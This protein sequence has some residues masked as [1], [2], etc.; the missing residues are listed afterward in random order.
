MK[1]QITSFLLAALVTF[2]AVAETRAQGTAFTYQGRLLQGTSPYSGAAEMRFI[3]FAVPS[4]GLPIST[5]APA[6]AIV[7]VSNGMFVA[8]LDFGPT[9]FS[10]GDRWI[11]IQLRTDLGDFIPLSPRQRVTPAPFALTARNV[12]GLDGHTLRTPDQNASPAVTVGPNGAVGIGTAAPVETLDIRSDDGSYVRVDR[13][14]G[15]IKVNGGSD[16]HW[17]I[18]NDGPSTGGTHLIG[19]GQTR[20]FVANMGNVGIGTLRPAERLDVEGNI[21][22]RDSVRLGSSGQWHATASDEILRMV[23]GSFNADGTIVAGSGFSVER[24]P[25]GQ[26]LITFHTPFSGTPTVTATTGYGQSYFAIQVQI[27]DLSSGGCDL[28]ST[29]SD[30]GPYTNRPVHFIAIGPR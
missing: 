3:M 23:R 1:P 29:P 9:A 26:Y 10:D 5:S 14:N 16:G 2:T 8:S 21:R 18:F 19:E 22:V 7:T 15:D 13:E 11:E 27:A 4:G 28:R 24:I 12:I 20:L 25:P 30:H 6:P 17:G